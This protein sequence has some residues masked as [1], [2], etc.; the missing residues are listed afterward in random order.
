MSTRAPVSAVLIILA[1]FAGLTGVHLAYTLAY[2]MLMTLVASYLWSRMLARKLKVERKSP[3]GSYTVGDQFEELFTVRNLS[4]LPL[5]YCEVNDYTR[6]TSYRPDRVCALRGGDAIAWR[7]RGTFERRGKHRFGPMVARLGDPF[8]LFPRTVNVQPA[9]EVV[10]FPAIH[11]LDETLITWAGGTFDTTSSGTPQDRAPDVSTIR[12]YVDGDPL[13]RV[14]WAS[15]ART[16]QLMSRVYDTRQSSDQLLV[17]DL[18][19]GIHAGTAPESSL[20]YAISICASMAHAGVRSG[21]A[22]GLITNDAAGTLIGPGRGEAHRMRIM[23]Y[24]ALAQD[25]GHIGL[26]D[27]VSRHGKTWQ[28]RGGLTVITASSDMSWI[29]ALIDVGVRGQRHLAVVVDPTSFGAPGTPMRV[30]SA[31]RLAANWWVVRRGDALS[32]STI[33]VASM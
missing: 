20:E 28:G 12:P 11:H 18:Q 14:H 30:S 7:A 27:V 6:L 3:A 16:G 25:D 4:H 15:S 10:V 21:K 2:L 32:G 9:A 33:R 5:P 8:G 17:L 29:E 24:L 31:W 22:V 13:S 19:R 23:E 26:A 1:V